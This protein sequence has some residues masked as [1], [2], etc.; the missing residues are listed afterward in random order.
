MTDGAFEILVDGATLSGRS[1]GEGPVLLVLHG[2]PGLSDYS[3]MFV[4][5][6]EGWQA[7][8]YTQRGTPPSTTEG[9]YTVGRHVDDALAVLDAH[10]IDQAV[11]VG[12]SWG[13]F[14]ACCIAAVA[15]RRVAGMVIVDAPGLVGDGGMA[16]FDAA[17]MARTP[18]ENLAR[19]QQLDEQMTSGR[20]PSDDEFRE[21]VALTFPSYFAD[22]AQ[23][24]SMPDSIHASFA[25]FTGTIA[26]IETEL[27]TGAAAT[28]LAS[29]NGPVDVMFGEL[30]PMP[31]HVARETAAH[32]PDATLSPVPGAGHFVWIER[33][34]SLRDALRRLTDRLKTNRR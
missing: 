26:S 16:E 23:A 33:P 1:T 24:P 8:R 10:R 30:S 12:H 15:P 4:D 18:A 6:L 34:G 7:L 28:A 22:P 27:E 3:D 19:L 20:E 29:F 31:A 13:G 25:T 11:L 32:F 5:E 2:G 14:L 9:P 21:L 17:L